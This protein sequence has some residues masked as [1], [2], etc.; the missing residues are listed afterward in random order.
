MMTQKDFEEQ[1]AT[2]APQIFGYTEPN[3]VGV[4]TV[5]YITV[6]KCKDFLLFTMRGS[7]TQITEVRIPV[8]E[9]W[10][11]GCTLI[12]ET[13]HR[14]VEDTEVYEYGLRIEGESHPIY[15]LHTVSTL[16]EFIDSIVGNPSNPKSAVVM[17]LTSGGHYAVNPKYVQSYIG[18]NTRFYEEPTVEWGSSWQ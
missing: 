14:P 4:S 11:L 12:N 13:P 15:V 3:Q 9:C 7:N 17:T 18:P 8:G 1:A 16:E 10:N 5:P 6:H 2:W